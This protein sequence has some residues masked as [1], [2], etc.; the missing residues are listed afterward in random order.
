MFALVGNMRLMR[1]MRLNLHSEV[2]GKNNE[3]KDAKTLA[4]GDGNYRVS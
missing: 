3:L 1:A 4:R 2:A